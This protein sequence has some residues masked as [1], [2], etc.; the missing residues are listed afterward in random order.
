MTVNRRIR[1]NVWGP[2][3]RFIWSRSLLESLLIIL[4]FFVGLWVLNPD[5]QTLARAE[6]GTL[7]LYGIQEG[8][9]GL[10]FLFVSLVHKSAIHQR[11]PR[12]RFVLC[13]AWL[14]LWGTVEVSILMA[15]WT[16]VIAVFGALPAVV[17]ML[18]ALRLVLPRDRIFHNDA[19]CE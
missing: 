19:D 10:V 12:I 16:S 8:V 9:W 3:E 7:R 14:V 6:G 4:G 13:M 17:A 11:A 18:A 1:R 5:V 15:R 2:I